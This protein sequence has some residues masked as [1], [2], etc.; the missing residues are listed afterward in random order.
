MTEECV[1]GASSVNPVSEFRHGSAALSLA[2]THKVE[3]F[4]QLG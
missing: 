3:I 4:F 1:L 2:F